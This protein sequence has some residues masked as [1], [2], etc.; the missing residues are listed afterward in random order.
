MLHF[1]NNILLKKIF[2]SFLLLFLELKLEGMNIE[3]RRLAHITARRL[4]LRSVSKGKELNRYMLIKRNHVRGKLYSC[5]SMNET[6]VAYK[7]KNF[8]PSVGVEEIFLNC[9]FLEIF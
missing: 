1:R 3:E 9:F 6:Q 7:L 5:M 4:D 2:L 8:L